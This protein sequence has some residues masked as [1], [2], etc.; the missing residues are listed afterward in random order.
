LQSRVLLPAGDGGNAEFRERV[1]AIS[2][3]L[4][5]LDLLDR[6]MSARAVGRD[7]DTRARHS[8]AFVK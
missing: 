8:V 3:A 6:I 4:L 5:P 1:D 2:V 7:R